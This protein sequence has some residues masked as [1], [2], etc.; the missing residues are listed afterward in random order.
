MDRMPLP[1]GDL[2][3]LCPQPIGSATNP[4]A[5]GGLAA[6]IQQSASVQEGTVMLVGTG[7]LAWF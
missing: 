1:K 4:L 3:Q 7:S 6:V 5:A 2:H